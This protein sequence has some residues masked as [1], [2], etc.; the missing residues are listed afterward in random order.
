MSGIT[1]RLTVS[2][3]SQ[4]ILDM[5]KT[6]VYRESLFETF[7]PVATKQQISQAIRHAKQ[8]GL[9]SVA[10][11]RDPELGT[12]YQLDQVKFN[13]LQHSLQTVVPLA[14]EDGLQRMTEAIVTI[15]L[16]LTVAAGS[17]IALL[18]MGVF[19]LLTQ[20]SSTGWGL[21]TGAVSGAAIWALQKA[22]AKKI[23]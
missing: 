14:K 23:M 2:E 21:I 20:N 4:R 7:Q 22:L 13:S 6:G 12:Y 1:R 8:F 10:K 3:L 17:A 15:R 11:L 18:A 19:C 5:A 9:H 16:M